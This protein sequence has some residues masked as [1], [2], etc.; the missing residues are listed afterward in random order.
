MTRQ[1]SRLSAELAAIAHEA[2]SLILK[3]YAERSDVRTKADAS[4]VTKAD[5]EAE[6]VILDRLARLQPGIPVIAEESVAKGHIPDL[7]ARFFL[8]DPLDGT[9]EFLQRNGEFTVNIALIEHGRPIAGVVVAPALARAFVGDGANGAFAAAAPEHQAL[10]I[11]AARPIHARRPPADGLVAVVSRT[12]RDT[13][14][15]VYLEN[16][17]ISR[18]VAAGSSLKFCLLA[19]GEADL[20]PRHGTTMEWDTAAGQAVLEA[21]GGAVTTLEGRPLAY[22][23]AGRGFVNPHF[24]ARGLV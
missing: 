10:N 14:T 23:K 5:E 24:I 21:A 4:P 6:E 19:A 8:V 9:K 2:G 13:K 16:Y 22:G 20:Y 18:L 15:D 7:E 12:H 3:H 1:M 17:L 11:G